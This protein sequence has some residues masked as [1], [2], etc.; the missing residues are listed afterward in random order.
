M[1]K[2]VFGDKIV[3]NNRDAVNAR[4]VIAVDYHVGKYQVEYEHGS[5]WLSFEY[6]DRNYDLDS[7]AAVT[8]DELVTIWTIRVDGGNPRQIKGTEALLNF[9]NGVYAAKPGAIIE[10]QVWE[11]I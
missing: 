6:T 7:P 8:Q 2:F 3:R 1:P 9:T 5:A 10:R 4:R 11:R